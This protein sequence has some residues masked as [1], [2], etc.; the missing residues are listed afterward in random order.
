MA[1]E[2]GEKEWD[3]DHHRH[4]MHVVRTSAAEAELPDSA[5]RKQ[6]STP[7]LSADR[8]AQQIIEENKYKLGPIIC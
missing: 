5:L 3:P 8:A 7:Q 2:A 4:Q 1:K 6:C